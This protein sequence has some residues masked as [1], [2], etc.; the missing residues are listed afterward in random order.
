MNAA[1]GSI[2]IHLY[3]LLAQYCFRRVIGKHFNVDPNHLRIV[4]ASDTGGFHAKRR[5]YLLLINIRHT[6][7]YIGITSCLQRLLISTKPT[8]SRASYQ[9]TDFTSLFTTITIRESKMPLP[10]KSSWKV[11]RGQRRLQ[12]LIHRTQIGATYDTSLQSGWRFWNS[13]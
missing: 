11:K 10:A 6:V 9:N 13:L 2:G 12:S 3:I 7:L 4:V 5:L 8:W 1:L